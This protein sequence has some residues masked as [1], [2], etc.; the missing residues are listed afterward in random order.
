VVTAPDTLLI[1]SDYQCPA[2]KRFERLLSDYARSPKSELTIGYLHFPLPSHPQA[3]RA[4]Y[5]EKLRGFV[6]RIDAAC[7]K[8]RAD[9]V[10]VN[11]RTPLRDTLLRYL[12]GRK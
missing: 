1:F 3:V 9:Y 6:K 7:G 2:C 10:P 4:A 11:T 8:M 12:G 5:L